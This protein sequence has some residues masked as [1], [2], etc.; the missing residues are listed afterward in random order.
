MNK[1]YRDVTTLLADLRPRWGDYVFVSIVYAL[2][3]TYFIRLEAG[4]IRDLRYD[5]TE[6]RW[7]H[8]RLGPDGVRGF[9]GALRP[10][11]DEATHEEVRSTILRAM[12][13][14]VASGVYGNVAGVCLRW[15]HN[16]EEDRRL[17]C[18]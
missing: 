15:Y 16:A 2:E 18:L 7:W 3:D 10:F 12:R 4:T 17:L 8:S 14:A 6:D 13:R 5:S 11:T 1:I 9:V